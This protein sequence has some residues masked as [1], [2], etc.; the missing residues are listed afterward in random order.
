MKALVQKAYLRKQLIN[1]RT[2]SSAPNSHKEEHSTELMRPEFYENDFVGI[3]EHFVRH[4]FYDYARA[5]TLDPK[6]AEE[7]LELFAEKHRQM[8]SYSWIFTPRIKS[9]EALAYTRYADAKFEPENE[10]IYRFP[11]GKPLERVPAPKLFKVG[12]TEDH[13]AKMRNQTSFLPEFFAPF[14]FKE[15]QIKQVID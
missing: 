14:K 3:D 5:Q 8:D 13:Y 7:A 11:R 6:A 4:P 1:F 10:H 9:K 2:F 15:E 12:R